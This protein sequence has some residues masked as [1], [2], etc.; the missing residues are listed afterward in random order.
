LDTKT[1][2]TVTFTY[3]NS[4]NLDIYFVSIH[5][6]ILSQKSSDA[7]YLVFND[8]TVEKLLVTK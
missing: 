5:I 7:V 4:G 1:S 2:L 3:S 8:R 6:N